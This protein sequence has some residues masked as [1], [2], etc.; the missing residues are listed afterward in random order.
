MEFTALAV[1]IL[2]LVIKT[3]WGNRPPVIRITNRR[4]VT[5]RINRTAEV[6][7]EE[8]FVLRMCR[9]QRNNWGR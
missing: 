3:R 4:R 8:Y 6:G 5:T 9:L 1:V 2:S 7:V